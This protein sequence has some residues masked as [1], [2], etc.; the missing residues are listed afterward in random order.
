MFY[1]FHYLHPCN[2]TESMVYLCVGGTFL[3][4]QGYRRFLLMQGK[5]G[6]MGEKRESYTQW[7]ELFVGAMHL[8]FLK[9]AAFIEFKPELQLG[10]QPPVVDLLII[11]KDPAITVTNEIGRIFRTHNLV[12]YKSP[13]D[14]LTI[15]D[16]FKTIGYAGLYIGSEAVGAKAAP[17]EVTITF[18]RAGKP[19][20]MMRTLQKDFGCEITKAYPGIYYVTG[21]IALPTQIVVTNRLEPEAHAWLQAISGREPDNALYRRIAYHEREKDSPENTHVRA[22]IRHMH[23]YYGSSF[24]KFYKEEK[25]MGRTLEDFA[26]EI[27]EEHIKELEET[28]DQYREEV[29]QYRQVNDQYRQENDQY[30]QENDRYRQRIAELE[31]QL[32]AR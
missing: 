14:S 4:L 26:N 5:R 8:E 24:E 6:P 9:D 32:A 27:A 16:F 15:Q 25:V 1:P 21:A 18:V 3:S 13:E 12:E 7:H 30:R 29:D 11:K 17:E 28:L 23:R 31:A 20:K 10:E 19:A 22:I 2:V